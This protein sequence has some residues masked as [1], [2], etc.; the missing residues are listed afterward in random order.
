MDGKNNSVFILVSFILFLAGLGYI[1]TFSSLLGNEFFMSPQQKSDVL[2][3]AEQ[4]GSYLSCADDLLCA[5]SL[6]CCYYGVP[7]EKLPFLEESRLE[8]LTFEDC[9]DIGSVAN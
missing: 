4:S 8:C 1:W 3:G 7:N 2:L 5:D 9:I 6:V